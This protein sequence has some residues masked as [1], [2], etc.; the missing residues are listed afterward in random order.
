MANID[1]YKNKNKIG[2][3]GAYVLGELLSTNH[4]I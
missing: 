4:L 3:K 1:C 2:N